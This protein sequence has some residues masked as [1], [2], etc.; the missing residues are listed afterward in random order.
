M[1]DFA[2]VPPDLLADA[3]NGWRR[4]AENRFFPT[5]GRLLALI[6]VKLEHRQESHFGMKLAADARAC[7]AERIARFRRGDYW[8]VR[9]GPDPDSEG[10]RAPADLINPKGIAA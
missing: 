7:W 9:W 4:D 5:S 6:K 1:D 3:C 10:C 8:P 2:S